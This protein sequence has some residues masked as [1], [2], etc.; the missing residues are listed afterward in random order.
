MIK[1][2]DSKQ[3]INP[4]LGGKGVILPH[5]GFSLITQKQ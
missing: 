5:A 3:T 1:N 4:N 2:L